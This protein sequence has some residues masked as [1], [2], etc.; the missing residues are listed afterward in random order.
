MAALQ[1][2]MKTI[3]DDWEVFRDPV[4]STALIHLGPAAHK[5][6]DWFD[7]NPGTHQDEMLAAQGPPG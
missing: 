1:F 2:G 3:E 4:N 5:H 6:K 7:E